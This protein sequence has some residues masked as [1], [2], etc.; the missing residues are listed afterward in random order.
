MNILT[1]SNN[2]ALRLNIDPNILKEIIESRLTNKQLN[3]EIKDTQ[4][5]KRIIQLLATD[6]S[7]LEFEKNNIK[8]GKTKES[9][10]KLKVNLGKLQILVLIR[11]LEKSKDCD[12]VLNA[13]LGVLNNKFDTVNTMLSSNLVQ[14]GGGV[15]YFNK[16][17]KYK[18]KYLKLTNVI[19]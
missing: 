4:K 1:I 14:N 15:N 6:F 5:R 12:S 2:V 16:Y 7:F 11:S 8:E 9:F 18:I 13:L 10:D 19:N 17:I 3:E